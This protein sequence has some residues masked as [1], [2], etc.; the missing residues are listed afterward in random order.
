MKPVLQITS[1]SDAD[2]LVDIR[3]AA[4]RESLSRIGRF[5]P[6][7]ARE[8]FLASFDAA[9]CR[10]IEVDGVRVGLV[11]VRPLDDYWLLDHLYVLPEYQGKGIGAAVLQEVFKRADARRMPI[12]VGALRDSD[13]NGFYQRHGFVRTDEAEWDI[14]YER[15]PHLD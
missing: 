1:P 11:M 13:A 9:L 7:R 12:R 14:Y 8:R 2:I 15:Q 3:I 10:F 5:D 4:M 6:Q